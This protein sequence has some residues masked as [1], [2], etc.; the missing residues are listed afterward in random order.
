LFGASPI[1]A[2]AQE[3]SEQI[4]TR[5]EQLKATASSDVN[6]AIDA[7]HIQIRND[8]IFQLWGIMV[9]GYDSDNP[10]QSYIASFEKLSA[11]IADKIY[12]LEYAMEQ[13][14][15]ENPLNHKYAHIFTANDIWIQALLLQQGLAI[16]YPLFH[17]RE[18]A[19]KLYEFE[20]QA[21][22]EKAGLWN[23]KLAV[24]NA[25][26]IESAPSEFVIF[27]DS[28][29]KIYT[30]MNVVYLGFNESWQ[31]NIYLAV[32][33][34]TRKEL[35]RQGIDVMS[36][37]RAKIRFRGYVEKNDKKAVIKLLSPA[38]LE[39]LPEHSLDATIGQ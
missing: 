12:I 22:N 32:D 2:Y 13:K 1:R 24:L 21:R 25:Q 19:D 4:F 37:G 28:I 27:E 10:S 36:L 29:K 7:T 3:K 9:P 15:P 6:K 34:K 11:L 35:S 26:T 33:P 16:A 23:N 14:R 17:D 8:E 31:D 30:H 5:P 39:I 38:F 18:L 20:A